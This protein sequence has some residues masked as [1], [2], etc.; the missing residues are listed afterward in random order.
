MS[1]VARDT[2]AYEIMASNTN[3]SADLVDVSGYVHNVSDVNIG[4]TSGR[5]YFDFKIQEGEGQFTRVACFTAD[6]RDFLKRKEG[7]KTPALL[8]NVS[9]QKRKFK[10]DENEYTMGKHARIMDA[11]NV[12]FQW[13][14]FDSKE[15]STVPVLL[16]DI[17]TTSNEGSIFLSYSDVP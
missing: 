9:P 15:G 12:S 11:K 3:P 4:K 13:Q 1:H 7:S 2:A 14:L 5:R 17:M 8:V 6:K 10:P 16:A